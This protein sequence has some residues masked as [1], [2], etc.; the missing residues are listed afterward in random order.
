MAA[1]HGAEEQEG[2]AST[3]VQ[4]AVTPARRRHAVTCASAANL[5]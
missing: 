4:A 5:E 3:G 2:E 1:R